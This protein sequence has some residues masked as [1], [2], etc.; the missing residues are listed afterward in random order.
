MSVHPEST[1]YPTLAVIQRFGLKGE[2]ARAVWRR[3]D[4]LARQVRG[5]SSN[6]EAAVTWDG[7]YCRFGVYAERVDDALYDNVAR[8]Y[9][10]CRDN[11]SPK[12]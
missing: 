11:A 8:A 4:F 3:S 12:Q 6:L 1:S 7:M 10:W 5:A 2:D 9:Q